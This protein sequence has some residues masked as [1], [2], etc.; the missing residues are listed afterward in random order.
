[1][2]NTTVKEWITLIADEIYDGFPVTQE[3]AHDKAISLYIALFK[4]SNVTDSQGRRVIRLPQ[5]SDD[6][7]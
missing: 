2:V 4:A 1:M 7:T 5:L 6:C 3:M